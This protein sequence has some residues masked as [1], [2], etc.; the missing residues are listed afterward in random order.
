MNLT[1]I[2]NQFN[3][4]FGERKWLLHLIYWAIISIVFLYQLKNATSPV[5]VDYKTVVLLGSSRFLVMLLLSYSFSFFVMP[6]YHHKNKFVFWSS[7]LLVMTFWFAIQILMIKWIGTHYMASPQLPDLTLMVLAKR[8]I[9]TYTV[10]FCFF[11]AFYYFLD[12]YARQKQIQLLER[13]KTEKI[14]LESSFLKSQINPHFLFNTLNNIY[15]LSLKK[16]EQTAVIID[17]LESLLH[18][19]LFECKADRV[20]LSDEFNFTGSYIA[21]EKL[22]HREEQCQVTVN[23][24]GDINTQQIA[25][26]LLINFLENAFKHGTK[27]T[28][29]KSWIKMEVNV[30]EQSM[31]FNLQ[32][33]KPLQLSLNRQE[34]EYKGGIGLKNVKRRLEIL[35]PDK[36]QLHV[37]QKKDRFEVDLMIDF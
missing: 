12:I 34:S 23:I 2:K 35:Y 9:F 22:R 20:S 7:L 3:Y 15:A 37:T 17:R 32:N 29:G 8:Q 21:L 31:H 33:S 5:E 13:F 11:I 4:I 19:M 10:L 16:S 24:T 25:P 27:M 26:L 36:H 1:T 28:F 6:L 30:N 18:Y 14:A